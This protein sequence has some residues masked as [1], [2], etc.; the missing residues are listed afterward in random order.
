MQVYGSL[1]LE[2]NLEVGEADVVFP[3]SYYLSAKEADPQPAMGPS[4][5]SKGRNK[6]YDFPVAKKS[7]LSN[8]TILFLLIKIRKNLGSFFP[9]L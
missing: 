3:V 2:D 8:D 4:V 9:A 7:V 5:K 6:I 1:A